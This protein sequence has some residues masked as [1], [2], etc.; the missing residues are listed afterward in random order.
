MIDL[1]LRCQMSVSLSVPYR[2]ALYV[3]DVM[4]DVLTVYMYTV[5]YACDD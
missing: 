1:K 4:G 5:R 3:G 2:T